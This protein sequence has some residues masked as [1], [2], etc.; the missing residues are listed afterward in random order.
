MIAQDLEHHLEEM[1]AILAAAGRDQDEPVR[2]EL[3]LGTDLLHGPRLDIAAQITHEA[4]L[5]GRARRQS[6][7][8]DDVVDVA[9]AIDEYP[10][11]DVVQEIVETVPLPHRPNEW[12]FG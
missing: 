12:P 8:A 3:E 2:S 4:C 9:L 5:V 6:V 11:E 1:P 7:L 10:I